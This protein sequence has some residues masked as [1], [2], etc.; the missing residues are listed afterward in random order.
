MSNR[1]NFKERFDKGEE[2]SLREFLY[3]LMQGYDSVMVN[4]DVEIGGFDQLFNVKA[5]RIIQKH[6][7]KPEQDILVTTMLEGIDGRKMSTSWGNVINITDEPNDMY[8][9]IM[10]VRDDLIIKYFTLCTR[11]PLRDVETIKSKL[12]A[13]ENPRDHKMHLARELVTMYH[14]ASEAQKAEQAFVGTFSEGGV[15]S[16]IQTIGVAAGTKLVDVALQ[17]KIIA[18]KSEWRRLVDEKAITELTTNQKITDQF[19]EA[20]SGTYKIGKRRFIKIEIK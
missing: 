16:D 13:G 8:G 17:Q 10:S 12:A 20:Q 14:G 15:P 19:A 9:K 18:S 4:A 7:G 2:V 5:G 11:L 3:P 1:R 6:Y